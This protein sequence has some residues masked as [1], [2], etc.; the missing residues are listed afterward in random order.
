MFDEIIKKN[1]YSFEEYKNFCLKHNR[2][3]VDNEENYYKNGFDKKFKNFIKE[4][5][6]S[7]P[8]KKK[9]Y[10]NNKSKIKEKRKIN[11]AKNNEK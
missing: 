5:S 10:E 2:K 8:T 7:R 6:R 3:F 9:Y 1:K 4:L 11:E